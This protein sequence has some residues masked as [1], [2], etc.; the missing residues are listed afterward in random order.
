MEGAAG[1]NE[2]PI[3]PLAGEDLK[4]RTKSCMLNEETRLMAGFVL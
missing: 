2:L 3:A 1:R 4:N